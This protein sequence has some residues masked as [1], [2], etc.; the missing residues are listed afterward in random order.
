ME[1]GAIKSAL[2]LRERE[3]SHES[4]GTFYNLLPL[5]T[6]PAFCAVPPKSAPL[7]KSTYRRHARRKPVAQHKIAVH[8]S[9]VC[10]KAN[11]SPLLG[12]VVYEVAPKQASAIPP[13][14]ETT[15]K[16]MQESDNRFEQTQ[17]PLTDTE[18]EANPIANVL[19]ACFLRLVPHRN[20]A[21]TSERSW[22]S[23]V[24]REQSLQLADSIASYVGRR[25]RLNQPSFC[26]LQP[27]DRKQIIRSRQH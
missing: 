27:S 10:Q 22:V 13:V 26:L 12:Q 1:S 17:P 8:P 2:K 15:P 16:A 18:T 14:V 11:P 3:A 7:H 21:G 5:V 23:D 25:H 4:S 20:S 19:K 9:P 24:S 6:S